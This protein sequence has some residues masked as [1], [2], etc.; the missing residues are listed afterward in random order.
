MRAGTSTVSELS[1]GSEPITPVRQREGSLDGLRGFAALSVLFAHL[2]THLGLLPF[3]P[4]GGVGVLV[5]FVLSGYLI[6]GICARSIHDRLDVRRFYARRV[7]RLAPVNLALVA[8]GIPLMVVLGEPVGRSI[9]DGAAALTQTTAY[10]QAAGVDVHYVFAPTW[11]LSVEWVF[12]LVAPVLLLLAS[13]RGIAPGRTWRAAA[14]GAVLLYAIGLTLDFVSFYTLPV[15]NIGAMLAGSGVALYHR[16]WTLRNP[17]S[18]P[19]WNWRISPVWSMAGLLMLAVFVVLPGYT[20]SWGYKV[21]VFPAVVLSAIVVIHGCWSGQSAGRLLSR[22]ALP[23][24]GL[25]AY[26]LYLWHI[27]VMWAAWTVLGAERRWLAAAASLVIIPIVVA[28]SFRFLE[29]PALRGHRPPVADPAKARTSPEPGPGSGLRSSSER[30]SGPQEFL[31]DDR[32]SHRARTQRQAAATPTIAQLRP[33]PR[34]GTNRRQRPDRWHTGGG[35]E[36]R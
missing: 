19:Q 33:L 20:L 8:V 3:A 28:V 22:F 17:E 1:D 6:A 5:F 29:A 23:Y 26:S 24:V 32:L 34:T 4:L 10:A 30:D 36:A 18:R 16:D 15:A 25:R 21:A 12:Y 2:V 35:G 9:R 31:V 14:V 27:P 13:R 11:S 7:R